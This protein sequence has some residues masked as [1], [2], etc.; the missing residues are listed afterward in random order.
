MHLTNTVSF[1]KPF[2]R[3]DAKNPYSILVFQSLIPI[4][5]HFLL[6]KLPAVFMNIPH[7]LLFSS[8][9]RV[10]DHLGPIEIL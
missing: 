8:K 1:F 2:S 7:Y 9:P 4:R 3:L 6:I 5:D 10:E